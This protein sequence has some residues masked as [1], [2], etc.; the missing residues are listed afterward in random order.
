MVKTDSFETCSVF[1]LV[2][3]LT[4]RRNPFEDFKLY[5]IYIVNKINWKPIASMEKLD[6]DILGRRANVFWLIYSPN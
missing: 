6:Q 1:Q 3:V 2:T 4:Q 5:G